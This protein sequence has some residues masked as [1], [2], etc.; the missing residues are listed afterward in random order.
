MNNYLE[1][2]ERYFW[3]ICDTFCHFNFIMVRITYFG[4]NLIFQD[5]RLW[6]LLA[7]RGHGGLRNMVSNCVFNRKLT[8]L[9]HTPK[10][11]GTPDTRFYRHLAL[12]WN[13]QGL[14]PVAH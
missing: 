14:F 2:V 1:P 11:D 5:M 13:A 9:R 6:L 7:D 10:P 3:I 8:M 12:P 4:K